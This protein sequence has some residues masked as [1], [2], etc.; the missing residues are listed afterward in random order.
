MHTLD[1]TLLAVALGALFAACIATSRLMRGVSGYL[2]ASRCAGRYL[3]TLSE[4][5]AGLGAITIIGTFEVFYSAGFV[6]LWWGYFLAPLGLFIALSG[7]VIY[8]FRQTRAMTMA[9]F[10][11][12]RYSRRFRL[13]FGA[14][15]FVSGVVNYGI[16]PAVTVRCFMQFCGLPDVLAIGSFSLP[17]FPALMALELGLAITLVWLGGQI[18]I[19]VSD[20]LQAVF[21][22]IVFL[23]LLVFFLWWMPWADLVAGLAMAPEGKSMLHPFRAR[24]AADFNTAYYLIGAFM[25]VYTTRAWQGTSGYNACA[26]SP[27]EARMAGILASWRAMAQNLALLLIPL[28][29]FA[30]LHN[31]KFAD[32]AAQI[33][34]LTAAIADPAARAQLTVSAGLSTILPAGFLGLFATVLVAAAISTDNTY[35]H[36]WGSIFIQDVV[37]PLRKRPLP[38]AQ[39]VRWLRGSSLGVAVFAFFFS[40]LFPLK[41]YVFMF[42]DI[43][44]AIF[45]G[46]AGAAII[47]G[48]YWRRGSTAGA[49]AAMIT[50]GVLSTGGLAVQ[51]A[52]AGHL[53][54]LFLSY[55]PDNAWLVENAAR[56]PWNGREIMFG[57]ML[58]ALA[59]YVI[60]SLCGRTRFDL[61]TM[62]GREARVSHDAAAAPRFGWR[63]RLGEVIG[64]GIEFTRGDRWLCRLTLVWT[65]CWWIVFVVGTVWNLV[66]E[67][68]ESSWATFWHWNIGLSVPLGVVTTGW[69][70]VGG[71]RD[72]RRML[73][74]LRATPAEPGVTE[75]E[76]PAPEGKDEVP[77]LCRT[78]PDTA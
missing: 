41:D 47:G 1:W 5:A 48:L 39:H 64:N 66:A 76:T 62:L 14:L 6:P 37:L 36:S 73:R 17:L 53:A 20:Y 13:F 21:C 74:D 38:A 72:F 34:A 35:L 19:L 65:L 2:V 23:A 42:F 60:V 28:C 63:E 12:T 55:N 4:G 26:R 27:H 75:R 61:E 24:D 32:Q 71:V 44:G 3:L 33:N 9:Q 22:M 31:P 58:A 59:V 50:G 51:Q 78:K 16:F 45:L 7:F 49:W 29:V 68:P 10:I 46:G 18:T 43:T 15:T 77:P 67:V 11:E 69:F 40:L 70:L 30:V 25:I 56:L 8:R 57:A 54:P 52:W